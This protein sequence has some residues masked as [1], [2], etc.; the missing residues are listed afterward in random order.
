M[1]LIQ[2]TDNCYMISLL[3]A[4][5]YIIGSS[6]KPYVSGDEVEY[7][8]IAKSISRGEGIQLF[9]IPTTIASTWSIFISPLFNNFINLHT[10]III[11]RIISLVFIIISLFQ[12]TFIL[13]NIRINNKFLSDDKI[14][15]VQ[16][17]TFGNFYYWLQTGSMFLE[18]FSIV[19]FLFAC[20]IIVKDN[21]NLPNLI[22][23]GILSGA[24]AATKYITIVI[25]P[26]LI[27]HFINKYGFN[28]KLFYTLSVVF[29]SS[30]VLLIPILAR[31]INLEYL[32]NVG[33]D[34]SYLESYNSEANQ[35]S[36]IIALLKFMISG[37]LIF[38]N[39]FHEFFTTI[40]KLNGFYIS[41]FFIIPIAFFFY[42]N[43]KTKFTFSFFSAFTILYVLALMFSGHGGNTRYWILVF[44]FF[45]LF[46]V[47]GISNIKIFKKNFYFNNK[48]LLKF[49]IIGFLLMLLC[50]IIIAFYFRISGMDLLGYKTYTIILTF[51]ISFLIVLI[52]FLREKQIAL[53]KFVSLLIFIIPFSRASNEFI[54]LGRPLPPASSEIVRDQISL[55]SFLDSKKWEYPVFQNTD[56]LNAAWTTAYSNVP[57][58]DYRINYGENDYKKIFLICKSGKNFNSLK[59]SDSEYEVD[60]STIIYSNDHYSVKEL[61]LSK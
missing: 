49:S 8:S 20:V 37:F 34:F 60:N 35:S 13:K 29:L 33:N 39:K 23:L 24:L 17:L 25:Y 43:I 36:P 50:F 11:C 14:F 5:L 2:K 54:L 10:S 26:A 46:F 21:F 38:I 15:I 12:F 27:I 28:K 48:K 18:P 51:L 6:Y 45:V 30:F 40:P 56:A 31:F 55:G 7:V 32:N 44:P 47:E 22:L 52:F 53:W 58:L 57:V 1:R 59:V 42:V 9:G 61:L 4:V 19:I 16:L 3:F 41:I